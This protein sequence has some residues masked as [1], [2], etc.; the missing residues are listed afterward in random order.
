MHKE[1]LEK[2]L[3]DQRDFFASGKT[4]EI[5]YRLEN[6]RKLRSLI[7]SHEDELNDAMYKDFHKPCFEV[8]GTESRFTV[9]EITMMIRNLKKWSGSTG[10]LVVTH[11]R[12]IAAKSK[13]IIEMDDGNIKKDFLV[14]EDGDSLWE[15]ISPEYCRACK[16]FKEGNTNL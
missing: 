5:N 11:D 15:D 2:I 14:S 3:I 1:D 7:L 9:A 13:R 8:L 4:L 10:F 16:K 12:H 6:L